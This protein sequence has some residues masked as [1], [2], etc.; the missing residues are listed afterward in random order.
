MAQLVLGESF[1]FSIL[2]QEKLTILVQVCFARLNAEVNGK[3]KISFLKT[4]K[5]TE[6]ESKSTPSHIESS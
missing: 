3:V 5:M 1:S 6:T 2:N 4:E